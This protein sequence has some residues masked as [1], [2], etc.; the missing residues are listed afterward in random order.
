MFYDH[1]ERVWIARVSLGTVQGKRIRRKVRAATEG[2]ARRELERLQRAYGAGADPATMA[3][4]LYLTDWLAAHKGTVR[5]STLAA[6][7][8]HVTH[9]IS[10]LLGGMHVAKIQPRDVRRLIA[11]RLAGKTRYGKPLSPTTVARIV[12]TLHIALQQLVDEGAIPTNPADVRLPRSVAEP[13]RPMTL[14]DAETIIDATRDSWLGPLVRFLLGSGVRLGEACALNQGDVKLAEGYVRLR[15]SKTTVRAV[16]VAMDGLAA[17]EE[18]IRLAPRA[19]RDEPVFFGPKTGDRLRGMTVSHA[20]PKLLERAGLPRLT[21]H[22]LRHGHATM[23]LTSGAPMRVIAEQLGHRNPA[24]T[25]RVYA[26]VVPE[27]QRA[28]VGLLDAVGSRN[29]SRSG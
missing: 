11:D 2:Q 9:H 21:P 10:P 22:A 12:T 26:H 3:L 7:Q 24:L 4:D 19:G 1:A 8:S 23:L 28:A 13:V 14:T 15:K 6:Y 29:G 27:S 20:L 5:A 16:P 17:L 18:A 25:A